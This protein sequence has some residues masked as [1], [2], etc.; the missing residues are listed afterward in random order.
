MEEAVAGE[1]TL[2]P[3]GVYRSQVVHPYEAGRQP[4]PEDARRG[5]ILLD[6]GHNFEQALIGLEGFERIWIVFLFHHNPNWK[7]MVKPP[8]GTDAKQGVFATRA[9]YRPNPIGLSCVKLV[10][11]E[12]RKLVVA[13]ADLLDGS[14]VLD[15]KPYVP[16][17]DSFPE[18]RLGWLE[19]ADSEKF[20]IEWA[21]TALE[22]SRFLRENGVGNLEDFTIQQLE[23]EP[24]DGGRKRVQELGEGVWSLAYRTWRVI[25]AATGERAL[26]VLDLESGYT[27]ADLA[28]P[29]DK[30][31]DKDLHRKFRKT[32]T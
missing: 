22:K 10:R 26:K 30:W 15:I 24:F 14:P 19:H 12:G 28:D 20:R 4:R 5:E 18:S 8:R 27:E 9:P 31:G 3:I 2:R 13:G 6:E 16:G 17:A 21:E 29:F 32:E 11:V 25:F 1:V 7:P 23:F